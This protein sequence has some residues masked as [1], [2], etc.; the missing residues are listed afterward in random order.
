MSSRYFLDVNTTSGE[1]ERKTAIATSAGA[2]DADKIPRTGPDGKL[3]ASF[4]P[5][6]GGESA[7]T[8]AA[9]EALAAGDW[10]NFHV[11]GGARRVRKAVAADNTKVAQGYVAAAVNSGADAQVFTKGINGQVAPAGFT[12]NDVGAPVF[13]SAG[14]SGG[15]S[16]TPPSGAGNIVQ[17]LGFVVEV[18]G[19]VR[20]QLDMSYLVKL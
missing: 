5:A 15:C 19:T 1:I 2:T 3:D 14:T 17:R 4:M 8:V 9:S 6:T 12:A 7:E 11:V 13:L 16:K 10:V 20:V 18:S